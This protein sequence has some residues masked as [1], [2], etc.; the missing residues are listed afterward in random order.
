[1]SRLLNK[2]NASLQEKKKNSCIGGGGEGV[3]NIMKLQETR[4]FILNLSV[5]VYNY[6]S[7]HVAISIAAGGIMNFFFTQ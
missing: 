2:R 4:K 3:D 5:P 7:L 1:M 6:L